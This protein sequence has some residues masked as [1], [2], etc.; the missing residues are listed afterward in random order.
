MKVY[1]SCDMEGIAGVVDWSQ[2]EG[3]L[4]YETRF[5]AL[6]TAE[7][8][9][10]ALGAFD[11]GA[12]EVIVNDAHDFMRN[13]ILEDLDPR[14]RLI[15]GGRKPFSMMAGLD[16]TFDKVFFVG[17]HAHAGTFAGVLDHTMTSCIHHVWVNEIELSEGGLNA[18]LAGTYGVP[19]VLVTGD[20][21]SV[22]QAEHLFGPAE[23]VATKRAL[24]RTS[25]ICTH[26][27]SVQDET[28]KAARRAAA[29]EKQPWRLD[30]P[31][32][33]RVEFQTSTQADAASV[34][35]HA[36]RADAYTVRWQ[37]DDYHETYR[38]FLCMCA[39]SR[40]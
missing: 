5:R 10:A 27:K 38:A 9:A 40:P 35:P 34:L 15:S 39:L 21:A 25:A 31:Y 1:I 37:G 16:E 12:T 7:A 4:D 26:P 3:K 36:E 17:Y 14:V 20:E 13:I 6:M 29:A 32:V 28:R 11:G 2:T 30:P 18:L 8:N 19:V 24:S 23:T 22:V 33:L